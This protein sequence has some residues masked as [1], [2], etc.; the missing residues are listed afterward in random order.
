MTSTGDSTIYEVGDKMTVSTYG[1]H[2]DAGNAKVIERAKA[3]SEDEWKALTVQTLPARTPLN[4]WV[5]TVDR[6]IIDDVARGDVPIRENYDPVLWRDGSGKL[7]IVD[8]HTRAAIYYELNE[9]MPVRI[10]DERSLAGLSGQDVY[11]GGSD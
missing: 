3:V 6:C 8:G 2:Y 7:Y 11:L 9:P 1:M 5:E 4:A 10:M